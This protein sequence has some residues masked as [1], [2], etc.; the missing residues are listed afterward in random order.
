MSRAAQKGIV[1]IA[2]TTTQGTE[3]YLL[4][5]LVLRREGETAKDRIS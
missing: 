2:P 5:P 3:F 1:A 4:Y